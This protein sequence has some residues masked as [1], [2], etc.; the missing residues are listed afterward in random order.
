M[1]KN[2]STVL[3]MQV[4]PGCNYCMTRSVYAAYLGRCNK[5]R[6]FSIFYAMLQI[7]CKL[8]SEVS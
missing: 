6:K 4:E 5:N 1:L 3:N 8:R 2:F 7:R